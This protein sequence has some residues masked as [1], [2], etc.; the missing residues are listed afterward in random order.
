MNIALVAEEYPPMVGGIGRY[1][2]DV[3][4]F[5]AR[6]WPVQVLQRGYVA[7][8]HPPGTVGVS[9]FPF[10]ANSRNPWPWIQFFKER[11]ITLILFNHVDLAGPLI[12]AGLRAAGLYT[13]VFVYGADIGLARPP[14]AHL[15]LKATL[16]LHRQLITISVA[17]RELL[18]TRFPGLD[19][20]I[21]HPGLP[22]PFIPVARPPGQGIVA[23]GRLVRRKGFDTLLH[24]VAEL[25]RRGL[26]P[27]TTLIGDGPDASYLRELARDLGLD[28]QVRFAS[29]L[30]DPAV[31]E[32][33]RAH[34]VFCLLPRALSD[35]NVE[36]FGIVFLEASAQGLPVVASQSG[37]VPDAVHDGVTGFLVQPEN[38]LEAADRLALLLTDD[39]R[40]QSMHRATPAWVQQFTWDTRNLDQEF[41]FL[42]SR[43]PL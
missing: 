31:Q 5:L 19:A 30:T 27:P 9:N 16:H 22:G 28:H 21:V 4:H 8:P 12:I 43:A 29:G 33:L 2:R 26:T 17:T 13:G 15:R 7:T 3:A 6:R 14:R 38:P 11:G 40:W 34:R 10:P 25:K 41:S 35:G 18:Q 39:T 36:G 24:A 23:V 32:E 42:A 20:P 37:G 1:S